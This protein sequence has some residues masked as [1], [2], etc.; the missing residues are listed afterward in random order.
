MMAAFWQR[1]QKLD[2]RWVAA[3]AAAMFCAVLIWWGQRE[4]R[5]YERAGEVSGPDLQAEAERPSDDFAGAGRAYARIEVD[6]A[7]NPFRSAYLT[8]KINQWMEALRKKR[9]AERKAREAAEARKK[10]QQEK[11]Q[12]EKQE[13]KEPPPPPPKKTMTLIYRGYL[14]RTDGVERAL[15]EKQGS[16][17]AFYGEGAKIDWVEVRD[18]MKSGLVVVSGD[19][20]KTLQRD[21]PVKFTEP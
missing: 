8:E 4:S 3:A 14:Q 5:A 10:A 16:G 11:K 2:V 15:I 6:P 21:H 18:I 19:H 20:K 17:S 9:E 12:E 1:L 7:Q 13:K